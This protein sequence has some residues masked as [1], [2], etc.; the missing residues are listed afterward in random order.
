MTMNQVASL[1]AGRCDVWLMA[2]K[3][4]QKVVTNVGVPETV[5]ADLRAYCDRRH[6][7]L[8]D[9]AGA[10]LAWFLTQPGAA[11][12]MIMGDVTEGME[13]A[14]ADA[15]ER[16]AAGVRAGGKR[17]FR[18]VNTGTL[19]PAA[20]GGSEAGG[21]RESPEPERPAGRPDRGRT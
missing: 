21:P 13:T 2:E 7:I 16:L 19:K 18:T 17:K 4:K 5:Y 8:R 3:Q 10:V 15:L 12:R 9:V 11:Q 14:Y 20:N 1:T 6:L